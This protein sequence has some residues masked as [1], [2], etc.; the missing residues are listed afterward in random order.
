MQV[1]LGANWPPAFF[2]VYV[3]IYNGSHETTKCRKEL[4]CDVKKNG[5]TIAMAEVLQPVGVWHNDLVHCVETVLREH[6]KTLQEKYDTKAPL[7]IIP[8]G[9]YILAMINIDKKRIDGR[10]SFKKLEGCIDH[11]AKSY[12][13]VYNEYSMFTA[14]E[15]VTRAAEDYKFVHYKPYVVIFAE[16]L[17]EHVWDASA[18]SALLAE[19]IEYL[20]ISLQ[21]EMGHVLH[22]ERILEGMPIEEWQALEDENEATL[23]EWMNSKEKDSIEYHKTIPSEKIAN[24]LAEVD[25][26]DMVSR[27]RSI[28]ARATRIV[29]RPDT[30]NQTLFD[31]YNRCKACENAKAVEMIEGVTNRLEG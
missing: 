16:R 4:L 15:A 21:H 8:V 25:I 13:R 27:G 30:N 17:I 10:R 23:N 26:D 9:S 19:L 31:L 20:K 11:I 7:F 24:E 22:E 12:D 2:F 28:F 29:V 5:G 14:P 1:E 18:N 6:W 3:Y